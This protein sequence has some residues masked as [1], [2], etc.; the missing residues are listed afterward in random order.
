MVKLAAIFNFKI[1]LLG[2]RQPFGPLYLKELLPDVKQYVTYEGSLTQ[3]ACFET[4]RW[5]I[6]NKPLYVSGHQLHLL[7]T[8][9]KGD[10]L[11]DNFRPIQ[12]INHRTIF[13][14]IVN[15]QL[16]KNYRSKV[17]YVCLIKCN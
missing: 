1:L 3:P 10:G 7:R 5:I 6:L 9:L 2:D 12:E 14:N 16:A 11:Q 17:F 13:T 15:H 4:V 8:S